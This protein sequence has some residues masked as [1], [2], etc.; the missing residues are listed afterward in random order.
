MRPDS[1]TY[2]FLFPFFFNTRYVAFSEFVLYHNRFL[3]VWKVRRTF[4]YHNRMVFF[5]VVTTG[6]I[7]HIDQLIM[8]VCMYA[9]MYGHHI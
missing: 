2:F 9:C 4:L 3:F 6:W 1:H 7:S 8:Y 5:F